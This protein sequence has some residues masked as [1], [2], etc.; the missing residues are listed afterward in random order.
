MSFDVVPFEVFSDLFNQEHY[1]RLFNVSKYC[2]EEVCKY[3]LNH[4]DANFMDCA[5]EIGDLN[6]MKWLKYIGIQITLHTFREAAISQQLQICD[7]L[8]FNKCPWLEYSSNIVAYHGRLNSLQWLHNHC[9]KLASNIHVKAAMG[10]HL[11]IIKWIDTISFCFYKK[12][13]M[14]SHMSVGEWTDFHRYNSVCRAAAKYGHIH[15]L[16]WVYQRDK[17]SFPS[18]ITES[19]AEGGKLETLKWLLG[20]NYE[21]TAECI[22]EAA[23]HGHL[24]I[25]QYIDDQ[26]YLFLDDITYY[27]AKSGSVEMMKWLHSKGLAFEDR[28]CSKAAKNGH[29]ELLQYLYNNGCTWHSYICVHAVKGYNLN[30]LKWLQTIIGSNPLFWNIDVVIEAVSSEYIDILSWLHYNTELT[31]STWTFDVY[32]TITKF[33]C[34]TVLQWVH[35]MEPDKIIPYNQYMMNRARDE[36][37]IIYKWFIDHNYK[38]ID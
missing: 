3:I 33:S 13:F 18:D 14:E 17:K 4:K 12:D 23:K 22:K 32:K 26:D 30:M 1:I 7:W 2:R 16:E 21:I 6:I 11:D 15:I 27:A 35:D 24:N 5:A 20:K 37:P 29:L 10:G 34:P 38:L 8:H 19:A 31:I 9:Y 25:L 28:L 36:S